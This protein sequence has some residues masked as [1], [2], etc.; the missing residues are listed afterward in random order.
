MIGGVKLGGY[1]KSGIDTHRMSGGVKTNGTLTRS[2]NNATISMSGGVKTDGTPRITYSAK[3][4]TEAM[5][6]GVKISGTNTRISNQTILGGVKVNGNLFGYTCTAARG[7]NTK[8][9]S[10]EVAVID[11][12]NDDG[13]WNYSAINYSTLRL[14]WGFSDGMNMWLRFNN[15]NIWQGNTINYAHIEFY[16][17]SSNNNNT[18]VSIRAENSGNVTSAPLNVRDISGRERTSQ[19]VSWSLTLT[20]PPDVIESPNIACVIQQIIDRADWVRNN[21]LMLLLDNLYRGGNVGGTP[22]THIFADYGSQPDVAARLVIYYSGSTDVETQGG[23][24]ESGGSA[25]VVVIT[26]MPA[27]GGVVVA[28]QTMGYLD[29]PNTAVL[30]LRDASFAFWIK[31]AKTDPQAVLSGANADRDNELAILVQDNKIRFDNHK[32]ES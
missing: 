30:H 2:I 8:V 16:R 26:V 27:S 13:S 12:N 25:T 1:V 11:S 15:I 4:Y 23:G 10:S 18:Q 32:R 3:T 28:K 21:S 14:D 7:T 20:P 22:Q 24:I 17:T 5:S 29:V 6:F 19:G 31:T 9:G